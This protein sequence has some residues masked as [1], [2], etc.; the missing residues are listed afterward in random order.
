VV[1]Q[2][3]KPFWQNITPQ[4][5]PAFTHGAPSGRQIAVV[6]KQNPDWQIIAPQQSPPLAHG[7]PSGRQVVV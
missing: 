5:S 7:A 3:Q 2:P 1:D 6:S 4:Q